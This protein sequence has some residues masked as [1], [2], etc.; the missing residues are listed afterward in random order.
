MRSLKWLLY[1]VAIIGLIVVTFAIAA[2]IRLT[3]RRDEI[4]HR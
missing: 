3:Q 4:P 1:R 2:W